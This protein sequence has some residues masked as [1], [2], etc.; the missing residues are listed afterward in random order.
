MIRGKTHNQDACFE[1]CWERA[2]HK[3]NDASSRCAAVRD[4]GD[5]NEPRNTIPL[6]KSAGTHVTPTR[7]THFTTPSCLPCFL[8]LLFSTI[9]PSYKSLPLSA[10]VFCSLTSFF[11]E[12]DRDRH[13]NSSGVLLFFDSFLLALR[14]RSKSQLQH[15]TPNTGHR[16]HPRRAGLQQLRAARKNDKNVEPT[17]SAD[18]ASSTRRIPCCTARALLFHEE[19]RTC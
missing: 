4:W 15:D 16:Q 12:R 13:S 9:F 5:T 19:F 3:Q 17:S 11:L 10:V 14:C 6:L 18:L 7:S 8:F 2:S 1:W